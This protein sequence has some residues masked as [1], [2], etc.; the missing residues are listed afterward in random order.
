MAL[1]SSRR[2]NVPPFIVMDI[3]RLA[4]ERAAQ[5]E[6]VVHLEV[7]QPST[8]APSRAVEAAA[9]A[10][11]GHTLGYTE[12]LGLP[13]LRRRISRRYRETYG[14]EVPPERIVVTTGSS[15]GFI[16]AFLAAFDAGDRVALAAPG[17][18]AYRSMLT[19]LGIEVVSLETDLT[20]GFQPTVD[21]LDAAG[22]LDGLIVASPANPTGSVVAHDELRELSAYCSRRGVRLVSDEVYHGIVHAGR[23]ETALAFSDDVIVANSFSKYFSMT[24]WRIGWMVAPEALLR[25]IECLTQNLFIA[26]PTL[27]Q[28]AAEA[29]MDCASEL[30]ANVARYARNRDTL[31][32]RLPGVGIDTWAPAD[33]A[34]YVYAD[35]SRL[36]NDSERLCH[37]VL[38]KAGVALTPGIDFDPTRGRRYVRISYAGSEA[39]IAAA[40]T[41]LS[42]WRARR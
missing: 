23:A 3:L 39:D 21:L 9:A 31:L 7:G 4:N 40:L 34:F 41:R 29:A 22:P 28:I 42:D 35:V 13:S 27:A 26:P 1:K 20:H 32:A 18:P 8:G 12:A 17:Y 6:K 38:A 36:T 14:V 15:G 11:R 37:D 2:G 5:G 24:G 30:D 19:A 25:P 33:G 16:L 10:L